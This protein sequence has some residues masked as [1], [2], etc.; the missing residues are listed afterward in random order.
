MTIEE[1]GKAAR[2]ARAKAEKAREAVEKQQRD[3]D[4]HWT[5]YEKVRDNPESPTRKRLV[6]KLREDHDDINRLL[7]EWERLMNAARAAEREYYDAVTKD[8]L[9]KKP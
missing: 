4:R 2:D 9:S 6:E 5:D 3:Y 7:D 8:L 1:L